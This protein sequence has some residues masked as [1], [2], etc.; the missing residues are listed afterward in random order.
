[1]R[2]WSLAWVA[3]LLCGCSAEPSL[4]LVRLGSG[5]WAPSV[6]GDP[7][8]L[9]RDEEQSV[10]AGLRPGFHVV[11]GPADWQ[12]ARAEGTDTSMPSVDTGRKMLLVAVSGRPDVVRTRI[13]RAIESTGALAVWVRETHAGKGCRLGT[14]E[15][16]P[17]DA[18]TVPRLD[19]PVRVY[20]E[21]DRAESC[22]EV[23]RPD[24]SC[25]LAGS[26]AWTTKLSAKTADRIECTLTVTAAGRFPIVE[27]ELTLAEVPPGST[28]KLAFPKAPLRGNFVADTFGTYIVRGEATDDSGR[29]GVSDVM[30]EVAPPRSREPLVRMVWTAFDPGDDPETF[31]RVEL[32]GK[33]GDR[34]CWIDRQPPDLCN[35]RRTGAF[36]SMVFKQ[37]AAAAALSLRYV[38]ERVEGG[39]VACVEVWF[40]GR[41]T[42]RTCDVKAR[43][44]GDTL[45]L[46]T[47]DI[48]SGEVAPAPKP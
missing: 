39:P 43:K 17:Y 31:P 14:T 44:P 23:A 1:M 21:E 13:T 6:E 45:E 41:R 40:D 22:G 20:V 29:K 18:V 28:A 47:L 2:T 26:T 8:K 25:R 10:Y 37:S 19:K 42:A 46:G 32:R 12:T 34:E 16:V 15:R 9:R 36:T 3:A 48:G 33:V 38:D 11:R 7:V 4:T 24:V 35:V 27:R 5:R 30:I